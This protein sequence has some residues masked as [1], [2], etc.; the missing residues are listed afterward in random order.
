V[1]GDAL[2]IEEG[3]V[4]VEADEAIRGFELIANENSFHALAGKAAVKLR[5]LWAPQFFFDP[6]NR[7]TSILRMLNTDSRR[8][9]VSLR[10]FDDASNL[11]ASTIV[12]IEPGT[13]W[14]QDV[15]NI[16]EV[17]PQ[18]LVTG[19]LRMDISGPVG[20]SSPVL[21]AITYVG[22]QG[23][24][25]TTLPLIEEGAT[26]VIFPHLAQTSDGSIYTGFSI[27]N[28]GEE[29]VTVTVDAFRPEG[30]MSAQ[31]VL[32]L[33]PGTRA[34]D[35]V[36]SQMFFGEDFEQLEGHVRVRSTGEVVIFAVFGD[37]QGRFMSAIEGQAAID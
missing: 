16:F 13:L 33:E 26:E 4:K 3:F 27:L 15:K 6:I 23:A 22:F 34:I 25:A 7:G 36:R 5:R 12:D 17:A 32:E 19:F 10:A 20:T 2:T 18:E 11:L 37:Y 9:R 21:G 31:K 28:P 24:T 8:A 30:G 35:L 14:V 29:A 1:V